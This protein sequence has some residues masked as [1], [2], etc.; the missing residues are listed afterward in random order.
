MWG[1]LCLRFLVFC[2]LMWWCLGG[3][4]PAFAG[5]TRVFECEFI[6]PFVSLVHNLIQVFCGQLF[7][8][9]G[10]GVHSCMSEVVGSTVCR[11]DHVCL[12]EQV[13]CG[14]VESLCPNVLRVG[15]VV[16]DS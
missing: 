8:C 15:R 6:S 3:F 10:I 13:V 7:L 2:G 12:S 9:R 14:G 4:S 16:G 5:A 1:V 11:V